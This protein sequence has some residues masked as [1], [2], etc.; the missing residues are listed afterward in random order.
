MN[1]D[2]MAAEHVNRIGMNTTP[3]WFARW[4]WRVN[5]RDENWHANILAWIRKG[6]NPQSVWIRG[7]VGLSVT[8]A[9][10]PHSASYPVCMVGKR[11]ETTCSTLTCDHNA[12]SMFSPKSPQ[13]VT[14]SHTFRHITHLYTHPLA[15]LLFCTVQA[16][17][18]SNTL[19]SS[20]LALHLLSSL[21]SG[22]YN[23]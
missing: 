19:Y 8:T 22:M 4:H 10:M 16:L 20:H 6:T 18:H 13:Y 21:L 17:C 15:I 23:K 7:C 9:Y 12:R 2:Y 1:Y 5:R 11:C 14:T 3:L